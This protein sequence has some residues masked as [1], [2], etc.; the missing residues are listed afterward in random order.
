MSEFLPSVALRWK[1]SHLSNVKT[2]N[3]LKVFLPL[4]FLEKCQESAVLPSW[5]IFNKESENFL[6]VSFGSHKNPCQVNNCYYPKCLETA[7]R[8]I[9][10]FK[11]TGK[12]TGSMVAK[13]FIPAVEYTDGQAE[14]VK[15]F[16]IQIHRTF[17][18]ITSKLPWK[19]L[20]ACYRQSV[21]RH[22]RQSWSTVGQSHIR[23]HLDHE[24]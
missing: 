3:R 13:V 1:E 16:C 7:W 8:V 18:K 9:S 2:W 22:F 14:S 4:K 21:S 6:P 5:Y 15:A 11:F 20:P 19:P 12:V 17:F 10:S 23:I 24:L